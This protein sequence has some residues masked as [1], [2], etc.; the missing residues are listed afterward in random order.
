M[1]ETIP[2]ALVAAVAD[3]LPKN[4]ELAATRPKTAVVADRVKLM[5][6]D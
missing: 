2:A 1:P 4:S 5:K 3:T 6:K